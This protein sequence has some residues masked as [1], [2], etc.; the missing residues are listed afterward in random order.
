MEFGPSRHDWTKRLENQLT[1][2]YSESPTYTNTTGKIQKNPTYKGHNPTCTTSRYPRSGN[3]TVPAT[4][5][6][7]VWRIPTVYLAPGAS[8]KPILTTVPRRIKPYGPRPVL[9]ARLSSRCSR[10]QQRVSKPLKRI[11]AHTHQI[12]RLAQTPRDGSSYER[13]HERRDLR[14]SQPWVQRGIFACC[15]PIFVSGRG[16][17]VIH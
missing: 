5:Y 9:T 11:H 14:L 1:C 4:L 6:T 15:A 16:G 8:H 7:E 3:R 17:A 13:M 12:T 10:A 2:A